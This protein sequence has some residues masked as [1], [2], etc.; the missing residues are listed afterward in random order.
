MRY[1]LLFALILF[2]KFSFAQITGNSL[3]LNGSTDWVEVQNNSSLNI[4]DNLTT[5]AWIYPCNASGDIVNKLWC[6]GDQ[7]Q[8][9]LYI[10]NGYLAFGW[11][12]DGNCASVNVYQSTNVVIATGQWYHVAVVHTDS[13]VT[14]YVNG[15][16]ISGS[17]TAG[18]YSNINFSTAPILLGAYRVLAGTYTGFFKGKI[19]E[20]RIWNSA[21]SAS[22]ISGRY[23]SELTGSEAG[24]I[25]Y[26]NMNLTG[27]G[28]GYSVTNDASSTG[29]IND[30]STVGT[31]T[32]PYFA[33]HSDA[34]DCNSNS[35]GLSKNSVKENF[36]AIYPNP[37]KGL[38]TLNFN[39]A[40]SEEGK[41]KVVNS[42]GRE[43]FTETISDF[44]APSYIDLN[45]KTKGLYFVMITMNEQV[46]TRK[47]V[48]E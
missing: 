12:S 15:A 8:F 3:V 38:F 29:T 27:S 4:P 35:T 31:N 6:S 14:L 21:L 37:S 20:V 46:L 34:L 30:G 48:L 32:T 33:P 23:N 44:S 25:A 13:S 41:I 28:Q 7:H 43:V 45:G 1:S 39:S 9:H 16:P 36:V 2:S 19:D 10:L 11:D 40:I 22:D 5:E 24:L 47:I 17:L 42:E 18:S 26:Y